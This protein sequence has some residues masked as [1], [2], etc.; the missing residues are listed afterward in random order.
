VRAKRAAAELRPA[1][2]IWLLR[3]AAILEGVSAGGRDETP[4]TERAALFHRVA[5]KVAR[6]MEAETGVSL[7]P[8]ERAA[9]AAEAHRLSARAEAELRRP[10]PRD[11]ERGEEWVRTAQALREITDAAVSEAVVGTGPSEPTDA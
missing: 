9:L 3:R 7:M 11:L 8:C 6:A 5:E 4:D 10:A 1:H 2:A